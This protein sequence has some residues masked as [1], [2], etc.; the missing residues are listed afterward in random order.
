MTVKRSVN[1]VN[2]SKQSLVAF[3]VSI[4]HHQNKQYC[5]IFSEIFDSISTHLAVYY[6]L[7]V[8]SGTCTIAP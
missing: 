3:A 4:R 8:S 1:H 2:Q 5:I 6:F 7:S